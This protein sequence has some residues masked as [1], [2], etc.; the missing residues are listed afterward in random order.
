VD[1]HMYQGYKVPPY[2]DSLLGKIIAHGPT[3]DVAIRR[4]IWALDELLVEGIHTT[5]PFLRRIL[6]SETFRR[7]QFSTS[8]VEHFM[9][10]KASEET[11]A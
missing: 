11:P 4:M 6:E 9:N 3:R 2:Y 10:D 7:G 8:F 5:A 1:S